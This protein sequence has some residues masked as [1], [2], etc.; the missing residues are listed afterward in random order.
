MSWEVE[1]EKRKRVRDDGK[2]KERK[3][4]FKPPFFNYCLFLLK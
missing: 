4:G 3:R 2:G 1:R